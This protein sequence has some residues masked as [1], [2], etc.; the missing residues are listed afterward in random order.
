MIQEP[1][2]QQANTVVHSE[3]ICKAIEDFGSNARVPVPEDMLYEA[4][5]LVVDRRPYEPRHPKVVNATQLAV[6][7][8]RELEAELAEVRLWQDR[9]LN[10]LGEHRPHNLHGMEHKIVEGGWR[11]FYYDVREKYD[12]GFGEVMR[13]LHEKR[14]QDKH[15]TEH[16]RSPE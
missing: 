4:T 16:R 6:E 15:R 7:R 11:L 9:I 1:T 12:A 2:L 13:T 14:H 10:H 5:R 3:T 8:I